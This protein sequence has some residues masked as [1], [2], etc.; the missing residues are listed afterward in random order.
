MMNPA[1]QVEPAATLEPPV[2]TLALRRA[3]RSEVGERSAPGKN[4]AARWTSSLALLAVA[5]GCSTRT[6]ADMKA[7]PPSLAKF[8]IHAPC[9]AT[10]AHRVVPSAASTMEL[11]V[12]EASPSPGTPWILFRSRR[13]A[14][15]HLWFRVDVTSA[16]ARAASSVITVYS[17]PVPPL[18]YDTQETIAAPGALAMRIV[19]ACA[20]PAQAASPGPVAKAAPASKGGLE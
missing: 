5:S 15:P 18:L 11:T 9:T 10:A 12:E 14:D 16:T 3:T 8:S 13:L 7:M 2:Q 19:A 6:P 20:A 4:A 17:A 1:R